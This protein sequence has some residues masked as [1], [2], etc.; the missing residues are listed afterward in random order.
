MLPEVTGSDLEHIPETWGTGP[1]KGS[2]L[3][4][5]KEGSETVGWIYTNT[6]EWTTSNIPD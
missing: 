1:N 2:S 4:G 3:S 6:Y 5:I